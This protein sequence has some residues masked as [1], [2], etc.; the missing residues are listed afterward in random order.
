MGVPAVPRKSHPRHPVVWAIIEE[1]KEE[2]FPPTM[3]ISATQLLAHQLELEVEEVEEVKASSK[4]GSTKN[5]AAAAK[6]TKQKRGSIKQSARASMKKTALKGTVKEQN[7]ELAENSERGKLTRMA[8][9]LLAAQKLTCK[10]HGGKEATVTVELFGTLISR[11]EKLLDT[12]EELCKTLREQSSYESHHGHLNLQGHLRGDHSSFHDPESRP[13]IVLSPVTMS[14]SSHV[15]EGDEPSDALSSPPSALSSP[16]SALSSP[17][18]A[19]S[20]PLALLS[21]LSSE[22]GKEQDEDEDKEPSNGPSSS[23]ALGT[24]AN[25]DAN[26]DAD[27]RHSDAPAAER[28]ACSTAASCL[29]GAQGDAADM[30]I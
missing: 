25:A 7:S 24:N 20:P 22:Y 1:H 2:I 12:D 16:P 5:I 19:L 23:P 21:P 10:K 9:Q 18:S 3:K 28:A 11:M 30:W 14:S 6:K 13:S 8:D 4:G 15:E 26:A 27:V 17:P 29:D